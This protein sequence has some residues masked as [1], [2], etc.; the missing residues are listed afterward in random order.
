MTGIVLVL[1]PVLPAVRPLRA[2]ALCL[3]AAATLAFAAG[4]FGLG[5]EAAR[6]SSWEPSLFDVA[7]RCARRRPLRGL[8]AGDR[9]VRQPHPRGLPLPRRPAARHGRLGR[10]HRARDRQR[11]RR[12]DARAAPAPRRP[13]SRAA[14]PTSATTTTTSPR[15]AAVGAAARARGRRTAG[16]PRR[17]APA[18]ARRRAALPGPVRRRRHRRPRTSRS[19][20]TRAPSPRGAAAEAAGASPRPRRRRASARRASPSSFRCPRSTG[21]FHLPDPE[22]LRRSPAEHD[23]PDTVDQERVQLALVEALGHHGVEAKVVGTVAG[24]HITR[25][26]LRLAPGIKMNKVGNLKDD[27]AYALAATDI[28]ILAPIPGKQAVGVE[29]PNRRRRVVTLGDVYG[30]A[31]KDCPPADRLARQGRQR[32]ARRRRPREDA[33]PARRGHDRRRQV[34]L[35]QRDAQLDPAARDARR[36][37]ARA[38]RPQAGRAQPLRGD[39]APADAR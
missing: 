8:L 20:A 36:G 31:P 37:A 23:K 28:R 2:G 13:C 32:Q 10:G 11:R 18:V 22:L 34:R 21:E 38:R 6:T 12:H 17:R 33:A 3:L 29:V 25:Y 19:S 4:T 1:R 14:P 26:E 9:R 30:A 7:R 15:T 35:R 5:S 39:P 24:P 27:I 16:S